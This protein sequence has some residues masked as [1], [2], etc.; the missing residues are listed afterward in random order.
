MHENASSGNEDY[1]TKH[2]CPQP[3]CGRNFQNRQWLGRHHLSEHGCT[4]VEYESR[5][6]EYP[7]PYDGCSKAFDTK[8]VMKR[9]HA[10]VH[11]ESIAG[12]L[13]ECDWCAEEIRRKPAAIKAAERNFCR[14]R[15][16]EQRWRQERYSGE[17]NPKYKKVKTE[18]HYCG[19][20]IH[21][22][23]Y[24]IESQDNVFCREENCSA[25][26]RQTLTGQNSPM[27]KGGKNIYDALK[28]QLPT[29]WYTARRE[30]RERDDNEC[31]MCGSNESIRAKK[32]SV[33][34][35]VPVLSGGT[36]GAWNLIS[37]CRRCHKKAEW[38]T[39]D[40]FSTPFTDW[41]DDELPDN[42]DRWAKKSALV[43]GVTRQITFGEVGSE[44]GD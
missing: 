1:E 17:D 43:S 30:A 35:L 14:D 28:R 10:R 12:D 23:P 15:D 9:H 6:G 42:R 11:G 2:R 31:Q 7:C 22:A 13:V 32:M 34:H 21:R 33:H 20:T 36:H 41:A 27:W 18:C 5:L 39:K 25:K 29:P 44:A 24:R 3:D 40:L 38:Y 37:L 19:A 16:C 8:A 26:W 4:I